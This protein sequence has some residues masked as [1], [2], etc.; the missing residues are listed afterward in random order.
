MNLLDSFLKAKGYK[1]GSD[2]THIA[3]FIPYLV[4]DTMM[5]N[6]EEHLKGRLR[7]KENTTP[8]E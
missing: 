5:L 3:P 6:Y 4:A 1:R 7:Q 8:P 2:K